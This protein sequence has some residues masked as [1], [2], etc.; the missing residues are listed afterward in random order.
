MIMIFFIYIFNIFF[1]S[2][3]FFTMNTLLLITGI[4]IQNN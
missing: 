3:I 4:K 1:T 2:F